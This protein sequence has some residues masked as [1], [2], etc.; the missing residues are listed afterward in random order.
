VTA[1]RSASFT[2]SSPP[3]PTRDPIGTPPGTGLAQTRYDLA[4]RLAIRLAIVGF[5]L[6]GVV[7]GTAALTGGWLGTPPWW[8]TVREQGEPIAW[9]PMTPAAAASGSAI[10][11][12]E[13]DDRRPAGEVIGFGVVV[14]GLALAALGAWP[15]RRPRIALVALGLA[16]AVYGTASV[17][18]GWLETPP[19]YERTVFIDID[20]LLAPHH[21]GSLSDATTVSVGPR[22]GCE[23][24]SGC[25]SAVGLALAAFGA[26]Q[27]QARRPAS[28]R[29]ATRQTPGASF[30][31]DDLKRRQRLLHLEAAGTLDGLPCPECGR[32]AVAVRFTSPAP[33]EYR[34]WFVCSTCGFEMRAQNSGR[35]PHWS[36][37]RVDERLQARDQA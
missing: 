4:V 17:T 14:A 32:D 35:P 24:I 8:T 29:P 7:Y 33:G 25:V 37:S 18:G 6:A 20:I 16:A 5:G 34:T 2:A 30:D 31:V 23:W 1:A 22:A 26:W 36:D 27:S 11:T 19:W 9:V 3:S 12:I 15:R 10:V 28:H 21:P 13:R